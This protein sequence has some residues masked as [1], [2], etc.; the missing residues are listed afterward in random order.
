MESWGAFPAIWKT[1]T[2]MAVGI[3]PLSRSRIRQVMPYFFPTTRRTLVAPMLP[4]PCSRMLIPFALAMSRPKG[5]EPTKK[6]MRGGIQSGI[7]V[8]LAGMVVRE[9]KIPSAN[10]ERSRRIGG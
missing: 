10:A 9:S 1:L 3:S 5:V 6:A 7:V 4:E 2:A 8:V